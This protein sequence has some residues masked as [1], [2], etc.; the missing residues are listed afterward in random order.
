MALSQIPSGWRGARYLRFH[1]FSREREEGGEPLLCVG[2]D[3]RQTDLIL[4]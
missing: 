1:D 2:E 4:A 3:F